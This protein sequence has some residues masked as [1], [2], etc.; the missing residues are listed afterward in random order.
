M[1]AINLPCINRR[2]KARAGKSCGTCVIPYGWLRPEQGN[3]ERMQEL[4]RQDSSIPKKQKAEKLRA[5]KDSP[6]SST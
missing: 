6:P 4:Q 1:G 5:R 2:G 3:E